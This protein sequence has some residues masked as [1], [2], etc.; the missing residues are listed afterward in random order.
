M[1]VE[2]KLMKKVSVDESSCI[3]CG[4]CVQ[5]AREVFAFG[6]HGES[7]AIKPIISDDEKE[8]FVAMESCPTNAISIKNCESDEEC[9][10]PHHCCNN[11]EGCQCEGECTCENC[12]CK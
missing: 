11:D 2:E 1:D 5:L 3:K 7:V 6:E 4:A 12:D 9:D 10:C 8:A